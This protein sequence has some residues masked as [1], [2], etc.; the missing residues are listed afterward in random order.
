MSWEDGS[1]RDGWRQLEV[2]ELRQLRERESS[3]YRGA[4]GCSVCCC[5]HGHSLYIWWRAITAEEGWCNLSWLGKMEGNL[6]NFAALGD[7]SHADSC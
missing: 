7:I 1:H 5:T 6:V 4:R 2:G 3:C